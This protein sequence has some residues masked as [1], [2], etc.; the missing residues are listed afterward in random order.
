MRRVVNVKGLHGCGSGVQMSE[1]EALDSCVWSPH[2]VL[3]FEGLKAK[4]VSLVHRVELP[5]PDALCTQPLMCPSCNLK[6]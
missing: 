4:Q 3:A 1:M 2:K 5:G 6:T